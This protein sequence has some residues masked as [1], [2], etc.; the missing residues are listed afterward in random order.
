MIGKS[1]GKY[2][3]VEQLGQG[4]MGVVYRAV[5]DALGRG[6]AIRQ[7]SGD[8]RSDEVLRRF[9]DDGVKLAELQQREIAVLYDL[10][11]A[12]GEVLMVMELVRGESL[13]QLSRRCGPLPPARAAYLVWQILGGLA[14]AHQAGLVHR[15]LKPSNVIVTDGGAIKIIDFGL[16][17]IAVADRST[18]HAALTPS[19]LTPEQLMSKDVD[20]R[21]DLYACGVIFYGLLTGMPPFKAA[22]PVELMRK[23]LRE[24]PTPLSTYLPDLP[25][26]C[27]SV[28][29]KALATEPGNRYQ[30]ADEFRQALMKAIGSASGLAA[31]D[32]ITPSVFE[33]APTVV[34]PRHALPIPAAATPPRAPAPSSSP[35]PYRAAQAAVIASSPPP[36][37]APAKPSAPAPIAGQASSEQRP[38]IDRRQL[39]FAVAGAALGVVLVGALAFVIIRNQQQ[40]QTQA[41][42][43]ASA[44]EADA[45]ATAETSPAA[46]LPVTPAKAASA[47]TPSQTNAAPAT[48]SP[49]RGAPVV[50]TASATPRP[51]APA[52][53]VAPAVTFDA[54][55]VV[56]DGDK[57]RER[58]AR[59]LVE[60]GRVT[61]VDRNDTVITT[62]DG[63]LITAVHYSTARQPMWHSPDGPAEVFKVE[64]G[65]FGIRRGG[66]NW[67]T[68]RTADAMHVIRVR[69]DDVR[70][71]I[72]GLQAHTGRPVVRVVEK[73]N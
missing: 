60:D 32:G 31:A 22:N 72:E 17:R 15:D 73:R 43:N 45:P 44:P 71:V 41:T 40:P 8:L 67:I 52:P 63:A 18:D 7:L 6:V 30:T 29:D 33:G 19:Y 53:P 36:A 24:R 2:R 23:Q 46:A 16:S 49:V 26:W 69:D 55:A 42:P 50:P 38:I 68:L 61:I 47:P 35:A 20:N 54:D 3:I 13:A 11:H 70:R 56:A 27:Q 21:T 66:R 28:I 59:V 10:V 58:D 12:D 1:I 37:A 65:A 57:H 62:L 9:R 48:E 64:G 25:E 39:R 5:D 14:R 34:L 51:A 4:P